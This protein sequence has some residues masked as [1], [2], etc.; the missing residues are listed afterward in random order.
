[1]PRASREAG[2]GELG[3]KLPPRRPSN[4]LPPWGEARQRLAPIP[5]EKGNLAPQGLAPI[6]V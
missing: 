4:A 3:H 1:M 2:R 5:T 6:P